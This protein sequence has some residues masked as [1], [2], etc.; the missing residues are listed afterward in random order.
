MS[1]ENLFGLLLSLSLLED[2]SKEVFRADLDLIL[3]IR[4]LEQ[5]LED[6][7]AGSLLPAALKEVVEVAKSQRDARL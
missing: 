6:G 5:G 1:V 3:H 2:E 4:R 7:G